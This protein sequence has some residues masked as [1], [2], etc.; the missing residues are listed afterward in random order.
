MKTTNKAAIEFAARLNGREMG[1]EITSEEEREAKAL[2]LVVVFG[3][4]DDN[5][6]LKGSI[7]DE[8]PAYPDTEILIHKLGVIQPHRECG[9]DYCGYEL[10]AKK[11]STI[12]PVWFT[13]DYS[14]QYETSIPHATFEIFEDGEKFCLGLVIHVDSLPSIK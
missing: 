9:C 11:C 3:Y 7:N 8:V 5:A 12:R 10:I 2:G 4:S 6:E 13:G 14:W 1:E